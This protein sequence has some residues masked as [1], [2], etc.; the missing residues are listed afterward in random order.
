VVAIDM[1]K[2]LDRA[3]DQLGKKYVFGTAGPNTFD[4]SGLVQYVYKP[5]GVNLPHHAASQAK[6]GKEV[7]KSDIQPGDL[8]FS[9]W[10]T[11]RPYSHVGI[12][13][14]K[15]RIINAPH[16]GAVVRYATLNDNYL[17]HVTAVRR[18]GDVTGTPGPDLG[19]VGGV[20]GGVAGGAVTALDSITGAISS[21]L[22]PLSGVSKLADQVFK[23][24]MPSNFLRV[25]AGLAGALLLMFGIY[26]L[27]KE[28]RSDG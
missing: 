3:R 10:G 13:V 1:E 9:D 17:S 20:I 28:A 24:F 18:V 6:L 16:S 15:N 2:L 5:F 19:T 4:C 12:A 8:V 27:A 26:L 7:S 22:A 25:A 23:I 21:G 11:G 14:S